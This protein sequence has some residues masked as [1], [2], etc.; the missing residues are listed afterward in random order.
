MGVIAFTRAT[1]A[2]VT[3]NGGNLNC[4]SGEAKVL[5]E[6]EEYKQFSYI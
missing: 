6:Q 4:L 3:D 1:T 2:T 5:N